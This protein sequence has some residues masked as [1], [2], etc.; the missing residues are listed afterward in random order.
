MSLMCLYIFNEYFECAFGVEEI[1]CK[2]RKSVGKA[3]VVLKEQK[4]GGHTKFQTIL[5]LFQ[6]NANVCK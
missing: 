2:L 5:L 3:F 1:L 4:H 6:L